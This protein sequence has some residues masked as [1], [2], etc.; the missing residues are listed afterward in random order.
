MEYLGYAAL[1]AAVPGVSALLFNDEADS[2]K[3]RWQM[4]GM[5]A[6][7]GAAIFLVVIVV[8]AFIDAK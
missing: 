5:A 7:L 2:W 4:A 6:M 3:E 1:F 8:G